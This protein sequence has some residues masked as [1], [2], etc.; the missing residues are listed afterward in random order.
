MAISER[1][2]P[3]RTR[4]R[5]ATLIGPRESGDAV[6]T[7]GDVNSAKVLQTVVRIK[8]PEVPKNQGA[9]LDLA[10]CSKQQQNP[11]EPSFTAANGAGFAAAPTRL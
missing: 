6:G 10:N 3:A 7:N 8:T 5:G 9:I 1:V 4:H 2:P 11:I